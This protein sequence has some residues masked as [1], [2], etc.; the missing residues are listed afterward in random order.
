MDHIRILLSPIR[1]TLSRTQNAGGALL[2]MAFGVDLSTLNLAS[3]AC[4]VCQYTQSDKLR[5]LVLR[6]ETGWGAAGHGLPAP[7][8]SSQARACETSLGKVPGSGPS[9]LVAGHAAR[10]PCCCLAG[11]GTEARCS[12]AQDRHEGGL[13]GSGKGRGWR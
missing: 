8:S 3:G 13:A 9:G 11:F 7:G 6:R 5:H 2:D 10:C 12:D 4:R 1:G